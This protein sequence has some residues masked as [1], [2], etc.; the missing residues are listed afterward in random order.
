M[1]LF[2]LPPF[3]ISIFYW[4]GIGIFLYS[5]ICNKLYTN[6]SIFTFFLIINFVS[7]SWIIQSF[8]SGGLGYLILGLFLVC[9]LSSFI[10]FLNFVLI[11]INFIYFKNSNLRYL[12]APLSI[13]VVEILKEFILGGFPWNPTVIIYYKN[14][15]A[16]GTLPYIGVYGL[17]IVIHLLIGSCVYF[18]SKRKRFL[19]A[20]IIILASFTYALGFFDKPT[21]MDKANN[22]LNI[23]LIQPNI[24]ESLKK[25]DVLENF[26]QYEELTFKALS[27][28]PNTDLIIWPE[29]SLPIDLNNR[30]GLLSRIG[31]LINR[32]QLIILGSSAIEND[33]LFNRLYVINHKGKTIQHYDK[34]KLVLFGEYVPF[35][36]PVISRFLNLGMNYV[37][38]VNQPLLNLPKN[39]QAI[40]MICFESIFNYSHVNE[41]ICRSDLIIQISNDSWFGKWYGPHQHLANS[42][43]RSV[44]FNKNLIRS[45]PSGVSAIIDSKGNILKSIPNDKADFL[46]YE[47]PILDSLQ[48]CESKFKYALIFL[49]M[50][51]G[52]SYIYVRVKK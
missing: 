33:Q 2:S 41:N 21:K 12:L 19:G 37:S 27:Q 23:I 45:T 43:L 16:I 48:I 20:S 40:P 38:G 46:Y 26:N 34:Q 24:Y 6:K 47:Y 10:A 36:K 22:S 13:S 51:F 29:G 3:G 31:G 49:I 17:G 42:L 32:E 4:F 11:K 15:W 28:N 52:F 30:M 7:L 9:L 25:Y 39:V 18:F 14:L 35:V 5:F 8:Y 50:I 1:I 44:E